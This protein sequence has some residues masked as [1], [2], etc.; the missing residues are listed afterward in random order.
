MRQ[1]TVL[2]EF[3]DDRVVPADEVSLHLVGDEG[4]LFDSR[5][6]TVFGTNA[7]ATLI[8]CLLAE[9]VPLPEIAAILARRGGVLPRTA[10]K[11]L[12]EAIRRWRAFGL[13]EG[14]PAP[15]PPSPFSSFN[16]PPASVAPRAHDDLP[17]SAMHRTY[18]ILESSF[19]LGFPSAEAHA[20]VAPLLDHLS[21][22][23]PSTRQISLSLV[24]TDDG[25]AL[26]AGD[27]VLERCAELHRVAPMILAVIM[28]IAIRSSGGLCAV[29]ASA[30]GH[31]D[32]TALLVGE[33][34]A[35]KST[36]AAAAAASGFCHLADD[37][38]VLERASLAV[39]PVPSP[40]CIKEGAWPV[41]AE[42]LHGLYDLPVHV[43]LDGRRARY[44]PRS[45][46]PRGTETNGSANTTC[47]VFP[48]YHPRAATKLHAMTT[49]E[50]VRALLP[51]VF[52]LDGGLGRQDIDDLIA[53][54]SDVPCFA[55]PLSSLGRGVAA[56]WGL[57]R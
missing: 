12:R 51:H 31:R 36:L 49:A 44:V 46:L 33:A 56:L 28:A 32:K 38:V 8:W 14:S 2:S 23:E 27:V 48:T 57:C 4:I 41:L 9:G 30:V 42:R 16:L 22:A 25:F 29:H 6:Q 3:P 18:T 53:W 47:A 45:W 11:F 19:G 55:L 17:P 15:D 13:L 40:P 10:H 37:T 50:A 54:I 21:T 43:R 5:R 52:V 35:G 34:G 39:R 24:E 20:A 7:T 1:A 26:H